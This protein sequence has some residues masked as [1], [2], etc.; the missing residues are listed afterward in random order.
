MFPKLPSTIYMFFSFL[1]SASAFAGTNPFLNTADAVVSCPADGSQLS[2]FTLC[3]ASDVRSVQVNDPLVQSVTWQLLIGNS[4]APAGDDCPNLGVS[5]SWNTV[6]TA[7]TFTVDNAGDYRV[8]LTYNSA[9]DEIFYARSFQNTY[10]DVISVTKDISV[11]GGSD[12]EIRIEATGNGP[13][14][15]QISNN[16]GAYGPL[17][18]SPVFTNLSVGTYEIKT[19]DSSGICEFISNPV[20]LL[21]PA[22]LVGQ[23]IQTQVPSCLQ[24]G[25]IITSA[26]GGVPPYE[27]ALN[28]GPFSSSNVFS[29]L[30]AGTYRVEVRDVNGAFVMTNGITIT[31]SLPITTNFTS[32]NITCG[33]MQD[34]QI[35][36]NA[37]GGTGIYQYTLLDSRTG[38]T[39]AF[40]SPQTTNH[41]FQNL[42]PGIYDIK[43]SD[44]GGCI[45][46]PQTIII[47]EPS[48]IL[49]TLTV[50]NPSKAN[51]TDGSITITS[52]GGTGVYQYA[53][54]PNLNEFY[55]SNVFTGLA[56][57]TYT[58]V[59]Q[60]QNGCFAIADAVLTASTVLTAELVQTE[61][62]CVDGST[63]EVNPSGGTL[64]YEFALNGNPFIASNT[65]SGLPSGHYTIL[66]RDATGTTIS[67]SIIIQEIPPIT[68]NY[69]A[70][71]V[72]CNGMGDGF[73]LVEPMG[74]TGSYEYQISVN[75]IP[76]GYQ[77]SDVFEGL[78]P[79]SYEVSVRD[80]GGCTS[81]STIDIQELPPLALSYSTTNPSDSNSPDGSIT[82]TASGGGGAYEYSIDGGVTFSSSNTFENLIAGEYQLAAIDS[83]VCFVE[84]GTVELTEATQL[85][86]T[87]AI[88]NQISC[89]SQARV[90]LTPSGGVPPYEYSSNGSTYRTTNPFITGSV[91]NTTFTVRDA[92][93]ATATSNEVLITATS[94]SIS[95]NVRTSYDCD[96]VNLPTVEFDL[97]RGSGNMQYSIYND[98]WQSSTT[99]HDVLDG[100][101]TVRAKNDSCQFETQITVANVVPVRVRVLEQNEGWVKFQITSG[102]G[103]FNYRIDG[104]SG[105]RTEI[106]NETIFEVDGFSPGPHWLV[107]EAAN[108]SDHVSFDIEGFIPELEI[109]TE[110]TDASCFGAQ[111]GSINVTGVGGLGEYNYGLVDGDNNIVYNVRPEITHFQGLAPGTYKALLRDTRQGLLVRSELITITEP[112]ELS[113]TIQS[114]SRSMTSSNIGTADLTVLGGNAP[115][116]YSLDGSNLYRP[117]LSSSI[118]DLA[119][120]D[121]IVSIRD[122][123]GCETDTI[124]TIETLPELSILVE[125]D[126]VACQENTITILVSGGSNNYLY[127]LDSM[128]SSDAQ[129]SN[130]FNNSAAGNH[131]ATVFDANGFVTTSDFVIE[132]ILPLD[133]SVELNY[134]DDKTNASAELIVQ[135]GSSPYTFSNDGEVYQE[136]TTF[137]DLIE[138]NQTFY[139]KDALGCITETTITVELVDDSTDRIKDNNGVDIKVYQNQGVTENITIVWN[140]VEEIPTSLVVYNSKGNLVLKVT[141][142]T[143]NLETQFNVANLARGIYYIYIKTPNGEEVKKVLVR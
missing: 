120:G 140:S 56:A 3:G 121:H 9:P 53:I 77:N 25:E 89:N 95:A 36:V 83:F 114:T 72:T 131:Y 109:V 5:C 91:G 79:G 12:G 82:L 27:Y 119:I 17:Q 108:C 130:V 122:S 1:L 18:N 69:T 93:G 129:S 60:D 47:T 123:N 111:D 106:G 57:G 99:F 7:N 137:T 70:Q 29:N 44:T 85:S 101:Y 43:V 76:S 34:G 143:G 59:T 115:Y 127:A 117:L 125:V 51:D 81:I 11:N 118:T 116:Q 26:S 35:E 94:E 84:L 139:V 141:P 33:G 16:G 30:V 103:P 80:S 67:N 86:L 75:G 61:A 32:H 58:I 112:Q 49:V 21:E 74:G 134:N 10:S 110:V 14:I 113:I 19:R 126:Y 138:G 15:Y 13:F 92:T 23:L 6:S 2:T 107:V 64:P 66:V 142:E 46:S 96:G 4:C 39:I 38:S 8:V 124:F 20:V 68:V 22:P 87:A 37:F 55:T 71:D 133:F 63:V 132:H 48:P 52:E 90:L 78:A 42:A 40:T 24:G 97:I 65:F 136:S 104:Y 45:S 50:A 41:T 54:S 28:G 31:A 73:I 100:E 98:I 88:Q 128:D 105:P 62:S 135:G 102:T